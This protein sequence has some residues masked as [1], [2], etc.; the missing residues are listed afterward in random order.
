M[1]DGCRRRKWKDERLVRIEIYFEWVRE[2]KAW[3]ARGGGEFVLTLTASEIKQSSLVAG[4]LQTRN[5]DVHV[6][7]V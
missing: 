5:L 6:Q 3:I 7:I 4:K 1:D 2:H